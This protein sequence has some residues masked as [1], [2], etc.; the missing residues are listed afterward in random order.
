MSWY[1]QLWSTESFLR[2]LS[3]KSVSLQDLWSILQF[4][5]I[6]TTTKRK[7]GSWGFGWTL[8]KNKNQAMGYENKNKTQQL[9]DLPIPLVCLSS[10]PNFSPTYI[11]CSCCCS[12]NVETLTFLV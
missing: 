3:L 9:R 10:S 4:T 2:S 8:N 1:T 6:K 5:N 7:E 11:R 12:Q